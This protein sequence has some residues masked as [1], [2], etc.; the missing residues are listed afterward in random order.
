MTDI[1]KDVQYA[2][3]EAPGIQALVV[4]PYIGKDAGWVNGWIFDSSLSTRIENTQRCAI[5]V[6]YGGGWRPPL[7]SNTVRF[8]LVVVDIW[9][10][11]TR[12]TDNSVLTHDAKTKCFHIYSEVFKVLHLLDRSTDDGGAIYFDQ[13]R[14]ISSESLGEPDLSWVQDGNGARMLR[15]RFGISY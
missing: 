10:D 8:P 4:E 1:V 13:T 5:V 7:D 9:A 14:I 15:S 11:P 3:Q 12:D 6:S 2:L